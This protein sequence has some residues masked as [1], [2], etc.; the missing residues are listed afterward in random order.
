MLEAHSTLLRSFVLLGMFDWLIIL[1]GLPD[2]SY[3]I[4]CVVGLGVSWNANSHAGY[5]KRAMAV[6]LQQSIGNCAGLIVS[7]S[8]FACIRF[9]SNT[10]IRLA[11]FTSRPSMADISLDIQYPSQLYVLRFAE[12]SACTCF[13][14]T[15]TANVQRWHSRN[16]RKLFDPLPMKREEVISTQTS[17][18][19]CNPQASE[20]ESP[21]LLDS[22]L[23][24]AS[25]VQYALRLTT[26][27]DTS[28]SS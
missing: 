21:V 27:A 2:E 26:S 12:I 28:S 9:V 24:L 1:C 19:Y 23:F 8:R 3:R 18:T 15:T 11:K 20:F 16:G 25:L 5:Y 22:S 17:S 13:W 10:R 14:S 7:S 6:G 4:Y